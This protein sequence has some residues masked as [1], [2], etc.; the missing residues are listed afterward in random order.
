MSLMKRLK[1]WIVR[2][3]R[4][5]VGT[6]QII[7]QI[8]E[9]AMVNKR[10]VDTQLSA[11]TVRLNNNGFCPE[12][13]IPFWYEYN[14]VEMG[15]QLAL[16]DLCRPGDTV[17][18]VGANIGG[19]SVVMSRAVGPNGI[20]CAFEASQR[21]LSSLQSNI[22]VSGCNNVHIYNYV[23]YNKSNEWVNVYHSGASGNIQADSIFPSENNTDSHEVQSLSLDDFVTFSKLTPTIIKMDIEGAEYDALQGMSRLLSESHPTLILEVFPND[24]R[25]YEVLLGWGYKAI[26]LMTYKLLEATNDFLPNC[27]VTN[28]LFVHETKLAETPYTSQLHCDTVM[29]IRRIAFKRHEDGSLS[30]LQPV[31]LG[32]G[33]YVFEVNFEEGGQDNRVSIGIE[34]LDENPLFLAEADLRWLYRNNRYWVIHL[35]RRQRIRIFFRVLSEP[36]SVDINLDSIKV[37]YYSNFDDMFALV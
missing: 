10:Y 36:A 1:T 5:M 22:I 26:D 23:I 2:K 13:P 29:H 24:L 33:R 18:D 35:N 8:G 19:I 27:D 21:V 30:M 3:T 28:I 34:D 7:E 6:P 17:F 12:Y 20:V 31:E 37:M 16:R 4:G 11:L 9:V 32:P 14:M 15:V 25:C